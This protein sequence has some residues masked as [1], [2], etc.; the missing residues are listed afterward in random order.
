VCVCP[1]LKQS[2]YVALAVLEQVGLEF[3]DEPA[4][5]SLVLGITVCMWHHC[6]AIIS[7]IF[8]KNEI[9]VN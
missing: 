4:S 1:F 7:I 9:K 6:L 2:L 5:A 3:R 8:N